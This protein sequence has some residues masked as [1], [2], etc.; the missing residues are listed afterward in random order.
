VEWTNVHLLTSPIFDNELGL[1]P[2]FTLT[3]LVSWNAFL[4]SLSGRSL[5]IGHQRS[6]RHARS[7]S[8]ILFFSTV[9][10]KISIVDPAELAFNYNLVTVAIDQFDQE[11]LTSLGHKESKANGVRYEAR[12]E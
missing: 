1:L 12:S 8:H 6:P 3:V 5:N 4:G 9:L 10:L 2:F 11:P 7:W